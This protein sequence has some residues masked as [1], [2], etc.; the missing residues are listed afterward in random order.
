[1]STYVVLSTEESA[2][3]LRD[4]S[5]EEKAAFTELNRLCQEKNVYWPTS[6]LDGGRDANRDMDLL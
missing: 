1:M 6:D 3:C 2:S 4:L 5:L